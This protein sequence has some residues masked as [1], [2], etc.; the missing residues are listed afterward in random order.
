MPRRSV[1]PVGT[2]VQLRDAEECQLTSG[3]Y[4]V[5]GPRE[6]VAAELYR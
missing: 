5:G 4:S 6:A 1:P 2:L 3:M